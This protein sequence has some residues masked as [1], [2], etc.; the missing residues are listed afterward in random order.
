MPCFYAANGRNGD[1]DALEDCTYARRLLMTVDALIE[2]AN[3]LVVLFGFPLA[4]A[5]VA[6]WVP[7]CYGPERSW[8]D[9]ERPAAA[10][11]AK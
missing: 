4:A 7:L 3:A 10:G 9:L 8:P 11:R 2:Y 5:A 6:A 1:G